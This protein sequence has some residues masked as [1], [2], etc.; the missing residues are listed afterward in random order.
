MWSYSIQ[1]WQ[2]Q[3]KLYHGPEG[4]ISNNAAKKVG[5]LVTDVQEEIQDEIDQNK[6]W[7]LQ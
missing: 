3:N 7:L 6:R 5:M 1:L 4:E 2:Q